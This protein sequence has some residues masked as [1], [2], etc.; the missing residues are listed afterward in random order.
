MKMKT[1]E[2]IKQ[3]LEAIAE[4]DIAA[5]AEKVAR[6]V[7]VYRYFEDVATD[8]LAYIQQLEA[9]QPHWISVDERLPEAD[10]EVL[11]YAIG[12]DDI[13]STIALTCYTHSMYGY[14][15]KGWVA[16]WQYFNTNYRITHWMH[17]PQPPK[18]GEN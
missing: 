9:A 14:D 16:P 17:L 1:P 6:L 7:G 13:E 4:T 5:R 8:A 18:E 3:G 11:V 12:N 10:K 15:I 2:V